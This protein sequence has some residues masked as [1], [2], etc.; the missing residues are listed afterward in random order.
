M[1]CRPSRPVALEAVDAQPA[2]QQ[3]DGTDSSSSTESAML[4]PD[5]HL[6]APQELGPALAAQPNTL[7]TVQSGDVQVLQQQNHPSAVVSGSDSATSDSLYAPEDLPPL[8]TSPD[9]GGYSYSDEDDMSQSS[10]NT[11]VMVE[12]PCSDEEDNAERRWRLGVQR[13]DDIRRA[14]APPCPRA[15]GTERFLKVIVV[16]HHHSSDS[17]LLFLVVLPPVFLVW[18]ISLQYVT[19]LLKN[20]IANLLHASLLLLFFFVCTISFQYATIVAVAECIGFSLFPHYGHV[21]TKQ[22]CRSP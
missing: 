7:Q 19:F 2:Q 20:S 13:Q 12:N 3:K 5:S 4:A 18:T 1:F 8:P 22:A 14:Q 10:S 9:Y 17:C 11:A 15:E 16:R 6:Q 21:V